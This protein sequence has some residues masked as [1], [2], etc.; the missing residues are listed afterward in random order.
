MFTLSKH[1]LKRQPV[2]YAAKL[3]NEHK[4]VLLSIIATIS[5]AVLMFLITV[6][7]AGGVSVTLFKSYV[8]PMFMSAFSLTVFWVFLFAR[9]KGKIPQLSEE[10][11]PKDGKAP[12]TNPA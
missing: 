9:H 3:G 12:A 7:I 11:P 10:E 5:A 6:A 2:T 1:F 8:L 4:T